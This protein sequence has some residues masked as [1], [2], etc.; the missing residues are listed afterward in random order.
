[1]EEEWIFGVEIDGATL[2]YNKDATRR[3]IT[4][5]NSNRVLYFDAKM[6]LHREDGPAR[7]LKDGTPEWWYHDTQ[8]HC[9]SQEEFE[10]FLK[11]KIYW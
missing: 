1:M 9:S 8:I 2:W 11:L 7:I 6:G 4:E 3:K 10:R 5:K